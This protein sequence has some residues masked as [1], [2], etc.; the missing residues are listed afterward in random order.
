LSCPIV[1]NLQI[2][3]IQDGDGRYLGKLKN[4]HISAMVGPIA[5]KFGTLTQF[6]PL[7]NPAR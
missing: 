7:Q 2:L 3:K 4:H 6:D 1:K 5:T